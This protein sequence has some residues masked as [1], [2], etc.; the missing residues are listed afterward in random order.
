MTCR[1]N[2]GVSRNVSFNAKNYAIGAYTSMAHC[3]LTRLT[4]WHS[5][6][7]QDERTLSAVPG[8]NQCKVDRIDRRLVIASNDAT[9][10]TQRFVQTATPDDIKEAVCGGMPHRASSAAG[11]CLSE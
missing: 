6:L 9:V 3:L 5:A 11:R 8:A 10:S 4:R 7:A 1:V 2:T